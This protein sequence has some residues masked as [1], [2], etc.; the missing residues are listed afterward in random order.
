MKAITKYRPGP[1]GVECR[2]V[3]IPQPPPGCVR[4]KVFAA[5]ICGTDIH[6]I[7]DEYP[8]KM[9]V[10]LGHEFVGTVDCLGEGVFHLKVGQTILSLACVDVCGACTY[11]QSGLY[12]M[13]NQRRSIG[14]GIN[15][16]M[17]DYI[18]VPA[19]KTF[20]L[21]CAPSYELALSEPLACVIRA[22]AEIARIPNAAF[23]FV[24]GPGFI[25]QLVAQVAKR[26]DAFVVMAG[27]PG[28]EERLSLANRVCADRT[29]ISQREIEETIAELKID[30]FDFAFEC[31][32]IAA[33]LE[34]CIRHTRRRGEVI[35][36]GL[37]GAP[38]R[39]DLDT[40]LCKEVTLRTSFGSNPSTWTRMLDMMRQKPF[41]MAPY[42]S[43]IFAPEEFAEAF[44]CAADRATYKSLIG[45]S[46]LQQT[47]TS[48]KSPISGQV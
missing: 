48:E 43:R 16:A 2:E 46:S 13:C 7:R 25:G 3:E 30:G 27:V 32:G 19:D 5:G 11:C 12:M 37:F 20:V 29:C 35:Q 40:M 31:A 24:S 34:S 17:A 15:G 39:V 22:V 9:P 33:S 38:V 10:T 21:D 23:V 41:Q 8:C 28:D 18:I 1:D 47:G 42:V 45:F 4:I 26:F 6:I 14:S 44:A 36:V